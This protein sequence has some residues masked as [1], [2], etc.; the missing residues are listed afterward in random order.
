MTEPWADQARRCLLALADLSPS[1]E[2]SAGGLVVPTDWFRWLSARSVRILDNPRTELM[3]MPNPDAVETGYTADVEKRFGESLAAVDQLRGAGSSLRIGWLW[4]AGRL[5]EAEG[6]RK[7][8]LHPLITLPVRVDRELGARTALHPAGD[9]EVSPLVEDQG[10]REELE[11]NLV[12]GG[13]A[14][15]KLSTPAIPPDVLP[16]LTSLASYA[17]SLARAARL[18]ARELVAATDGPEQLLRRTDLVIV[19]GVAVFSRVDMGTSSRAASLRG[20]AEQGLERWTAFHSIYAEASAPDPTPSPRPDVESPFPLTP[21]QREVLR[22]ASHRPVTV[23]SGPPGTGKSHTIAAVALDALARGEDVLVAAKA[24]ATVDALRDLLE[25]APGP[26]PVVFGSSERRDALAKRLSSGIRAVDDD[27]VRDAREARDRALEV[28]DIAARALRRDLDAEALLGSVTPG[29]VAHPVAPG[30]FEPD[31]DLAG[32]DE[33]LANA[34]R[35]GGWWTALV[36]RRARRDLQRRAQASSSARLDDLARALDEAH[37]IRAS[38]TMAATGGLDLAVR[39]EAL[40]ELDDRAHDATARWLAA[41]TRSEARIGRAALG[42]VAAVATALR[43]G[44]SARREQLRRIDDDRLTTALPLW[45]GTLADVDD[46]L[47]PKPGLFDLVVLDESSSIDQP[48]AAPALLR[49]KRAVVV[50]DPNQL[51]HVSFLSDEQQ[52]QVVA[53]YQLDRSPGTAAKLDARRNSAF[54]VAAS[55]APVLTLDEHFR[56]DPHLVD[57]VANRLYDGDLQIATRSPRTTGRDCV[58]LVRVTGE[59]DSDGVVQ[60]EVDWVLR[61]LHEHVRTGTGSVGVITPFR[62]QADALEAAV[63]RDLPLASIKALDLRVGTVHA[64]QGNER[65]VVLASIGIGPATTA[66][67]WRF[68]DEPPLLTVLLTRARR[69]ITLVLSADPPPG[70]LFA[71]YLAKRDEPPGPPSSGGPISPWARDVAADLEA[72][73]VAV[74]RAYP[75]GRHAVDLCVGDGPGALAVVCSV[76]PGGSAAHIRR[77]LALVRAGWTV[78]EAFPSRWEGRRG[79]LVVELLQ[80]VQG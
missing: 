35:R 30:L 73:G 44:R 77:H 49:G 2:Q 57:F 51:R 40:R 11:R 23:V 13:G 33:L 62:A 10:R 29:T 67:T 58:D 19:A 34:R 14:L 1:A 43:S 31:A 21:K 64:F 4:V 74:T 25:R 5:P 71:E 37:A 45:L 39:W 63:L 17:R 27:A 24:D 79:E 26:D 54:D 20:W 46:L 50:G 36:A 52:R 70:S 18:P 22:A 48:L 56:S 8:V 61:A 66:G 72:A 69:H 68:V 80:R 65:D 3:G 42:A 53:R 6:K 15:T 59:R 38:R 7:R 78:V 28:R 9:Y 76:H 55:V 12:T 32:A 47:P 60:A 16:R 41:E 75:T